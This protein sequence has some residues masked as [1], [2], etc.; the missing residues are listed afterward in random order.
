MDK[1]KVFIKK[2]EPSLNSNYYNVF[3]QEEDG[4]RVL[5]ITIGEFEAQRM[6]IE[7]DEIAV[8][9]P[10][11]YDM[12]KAIMDEYGLE[13][14]EVVLNKF[15]EGIYYSE[16]VCSDGREEKR[17]DSRTSDAINMALKFKTPI[18]ASEEV[19]DKV[20]FPDYEVETKAPIV[21]TKELFF[22]KAKEVLIE[23]LENLLEVAIEREEYDLAATLRDQLRILKNNETK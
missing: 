17:F 14:V 23:D 21:R 1:K 12:F 6:A 19:L 5:N 7:M 18:F 10:L 4:N 3:L 11:T 2:L 22:S 20:G 16:I 9:R 13:V 15:S 8:P